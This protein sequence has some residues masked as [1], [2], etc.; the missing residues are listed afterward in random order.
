MSVLMDVNLPGMDGNEATRRIRAF[1]NK[2]KRTV[3]IV[4]ITGNTAPADIDECRHAGMNDFLGKPVDPEALRQTIV[5]AHNKWREQN[6]GGLETA[7]PA[8][9]AAP[10]H[11]QPLFVLVVDDNEINQKVIVGYL[12]ADGHASEVAASGEKAVALAAEKLYDLILM[13]VTLPGID[14]LEASRRIRAFDDPAK[15]NVPIVAITGN[16]E[17]GDVKACRDAGMND[18]LGK[19]IDP[20]SLHGVLTRLEPHF[21]D[22]LDDYLP[23]DHSGPVPS[24]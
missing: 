17:P 8:V 21:A 18:F 7:A 22:P 24:G 5:T 12:K 13:D 20:A 3:P 11:Q 23:R 19:P 1:P 6:G 4:A 10:G 14:G 16:I 9:A 15:N 2:L